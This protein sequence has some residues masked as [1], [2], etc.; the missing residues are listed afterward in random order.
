MSW[1]SSRPPAI[2]VPRR[3]ADELSATVVSLV[4]KEPFFGHLLGGVARALTDVTATLAVDATGGQLKLLVNPEF[5]LGLGSHNTRVAAVKHEALHLLFKHV[6][7]LRHR[8]ERR[9][10]QLWN[11]AADLVVN[12]FVGKT[13]RLP[14]SA[15]T[16]A[17]FPD[18]ELQPDRSA[19]EYYDR[20]VALRNEME[21]A[22]GSGDGAAEGSGA[23]GGEGSAG[24]PQQGGEPRR[25]EGQ[26]GE[27]RARD[28]GEWAKAGVSSPR[29]A[30][31]LDA[32]GD[33]HSD[34]DKWS[35]GAGDTLAAS[36]ESAID[37]VIARAA[38]RT[39]QRAWSEMPGPLQDLIQA[40]L[41]RRQ[42]Q[43]NWRRAMRMFSNSSRRTRIVST[44]R[45]ASRRYGSFPGIRVRRHSKIAVAIDTSGSVGDD[46][47][48]AFFTEV[49]GLWRQGAEVTVF[50]CDATVQRRYLYGGRP[51]DAVAGRGGTR[52]DPVFEALRE[53]RSARWDGVVYLTDGDA[54]A[55]QTKP[56]CRLLWVLT[57]DGRPGEHLPWGRVVRLPEA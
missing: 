39:S 29:S 34:H 37:G 2:D 24:E 23:A 28:A 54:P 30:A 45:R 17:T 5:F 20:L 43:V 47:L 38:E 16:L 22:T 9:D 48:S 52:F 51:P 15:I 41:D 44:N 32:L 7:R 19:D 56:P 21:R 11:I 25:G 40:S 1:R 13:W 57:P 31:S 10:T 46:A 35:D 12:Q 33:W 4:L 36:A 26:D 49:H 6:F 14:D 27:P 8:G 55:P 50:E 3:A 53:D 42:P 18:L